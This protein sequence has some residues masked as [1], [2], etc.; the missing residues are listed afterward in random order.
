[1]KKALLFPTMLMM[2]SFLMLGQSRGDIYASLIGAA[3]LGKD[4]AK[5]T[6]NGQ[7]TKDSA[8]GATTL[9]GPA[10]SQTPEFPFFIYF[11]LTCLISNYL[12]GN[13][14]SM[15]VHLYT[16]HILNHYE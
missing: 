8:P 4:Y 3:S 5:V 12:S 14:A 11:I 1:M 2:G 16:K 9:A 6:L 10:W 15:R 7:A 13:S